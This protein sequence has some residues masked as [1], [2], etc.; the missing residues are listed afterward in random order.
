MF[1][2][3]FRSEL[4]PITINLHSLAGSGERSNPALENIM[5]VFLH[6]LYNAF[7]PPDPDFDLILVSSV[8]DNTEVSNPKPTGYWS[9][10]Y[11]TRPPSHTCTIKN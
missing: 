11:T 7:G 3:A 1:F 5:L 9:A 8:V 4:F 6:S 10:A 2:I